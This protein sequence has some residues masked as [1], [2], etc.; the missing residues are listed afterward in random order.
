MPRRESFCFTRLTMESAERYLERWRRAGLLDEQTAAA[1]RAYE[2]TEAKPGRQQWQVLA[3]L[4]LGG[5]LLGAGVLLF[6]AAHWDQ[7]S[8]VSRMVLVL[9]MLVLFHGLGLAVRERWSG[10]ATAMHAVGT[11]AAGGAIALVGQIFNMQEHWPAAVMLWAM[12]AGAGWWLLGDQFQQTL[13]LVLAPAWVVSEWAERTSA[14][15]GGGT[16]LARMGLVLGA[17]YLAGFLHAGRRVVFGILFAVGAVLLPMSVGALA[18]GW[19]GWE[20]GQRWGFIPVGYRMAAFAVMLLI[21]GLGVAA[22]RAVGA[23][24][25]VAAGLGMVLPWMQRMVT[26]G[27]AG[28]MWRRSEPDVL[29]YAAVAGA[30][31]FLVGWGVRMSAKALVNY[32]MV[33]FATTVFWFYFSSVMDKLGRSLGL[34]VLGVLF[35]GGGWV[36]ERTRRRLVGG[37][38]VLA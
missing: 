18:D 9:G 23:P 38:E 32:G 35:L 21:A 16:Y 2:L 4:I 12:C 22:D 14:Y 10:L 5:I 7:V 19:V 29:A 13:T 17:V 30:A 24:V 26:D 6:V 3:A 25:A 11:V 15:D 8:P 31:V 27:V 20:F 33:A 1:I 34:I 36:L 37:M 28:Q